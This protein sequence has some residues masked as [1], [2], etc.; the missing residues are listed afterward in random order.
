MQ[1][2]FSFIPVFR[3]P[4]ILH[5]IQ[6]KIQHWDQSIRELSA[7]VIFS[8]KLVILTSLFCCILLIQIFIIIIIIIIIHLEVHVMILFVLGPESFDSN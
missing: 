7:H 8:F 2:S 3:K 1:H 4:L 5:L 6:T